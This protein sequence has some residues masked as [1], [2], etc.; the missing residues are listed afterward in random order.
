MV[1]KPTRSTVAE[2][3]LIAMKIFGGTINGLHR[4]LG[5]RQHAN[6]P[7]LPPE[8]RSM[9]HSEPRLRLPLVH[10]LVQHRVLHFGPWMAID[11]PSAEPDLIRL[12]GL[13]VY[14]ELP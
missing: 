3:E 2:R 5:L 8:R 10:H 9:I 6:V 13:E 12:A 4:P 7:R 11:V 1:L 14:R